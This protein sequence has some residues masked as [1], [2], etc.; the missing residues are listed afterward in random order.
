MYSTTTSHMKKLFIG[1]LLLMVM[2]APITVYAQ[3]DTPAADTLQMTTEAG[4]PSAITQETQRSNYDLPYPGLLADNPLYFLK[5]A[6]DGLVG[7]LITNPQKKATFDILQADKRLA[8]AESLINKDK[9]KYALAISTLSKAE[10]YM[11][12]AIL[13]TKQA[14]KEGLETN[15][16]ETALQKSVHKHLEDLT[17]LAA[18]APKEQKE[19]MKSMVKRVQSFTKTVDQIVSKSTA[20]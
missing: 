6:R 13:K 12:E 10:N 1:V 11:E 20:K 19:A 5:V 8:G 7:A 16:L 17:D 14:Q 4:T 15:E 2:F 9:K 18:T 3:T